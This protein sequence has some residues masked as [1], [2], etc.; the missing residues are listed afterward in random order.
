MSGPPA[1]FVSYSRPSPYLELIG[2]VFEAASD[3]SLVRLHVEGRHTNARGF[4][5]A[6]VLVTLADIVMGHTAHRAGPP[7]IGLVTVSLTTDFPGTA[8]SGDWIEG[9]ATVTRRGRQLAFT[10]CEFTSGPRLVLA[11]S[12]VFAA[13]PGRERP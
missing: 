4:L 5:H 7:E 2:P 8:R 10:R 6:G 3:P 12:G 13:V 11:A 9:H 1:G